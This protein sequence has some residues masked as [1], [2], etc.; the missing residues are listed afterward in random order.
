MK[1]VFGYICTKDKCGKQIVACVSLDKH[2]GLQLHRFDIC[3]L[4]WVLVSSAILSAEIMHEALLS[5]F[6]YRSREWAL[7]EI[8][9]ELAKNRKL[10]EDLFYPSKAD[11]VRQTPCQEAT[12]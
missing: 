9:A 11:C 1:K 6:G 4:R 5:G 2:G 7:E 3:G 12:E 8:D 10:I